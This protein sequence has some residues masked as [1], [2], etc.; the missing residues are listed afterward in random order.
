MTNTF[1]LAGIGIGTEIENSYWNWNWNRNRSWRNLPITTL[2]IRMVAWVHSK[3][4][5][6]QAERNLLGACWTRKGRGIGVICPQGKLLSLVNIQHSSW[7]TGP[8]WHFTRTTLRMDLNIGQNMP[9]WY[10]QIPWHFMT[11]PLS[12]VHW[13][14]RQHFKRMLDILFLFLIRPNNGHFSLNNHPLAFTCPTSILPVPDRR[15]VYNFHTGFWSS[16]VRLMMIWTQGN[17]SR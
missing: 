14:L 15:T 11:R 5:V 6:K 12:R 7:T 1:I 17:W 2:D 13:G 10:G 8:S 9:F 3:S 16:F 4:T